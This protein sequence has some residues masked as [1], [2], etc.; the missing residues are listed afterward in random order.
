MESLHASCFMRTALALLRFLTSLERAK[1]ALGGNFVYCLAIH[2]LLVQLDKEFGGKVKVLAFGDDVHFLG[3]P[4]FAVS[5][6]SRWGFL[7][8]SAGADQSKEVPVL[9]ATGG[10]DHSSRGGASSQGAFYLTRHPGPWGPG[11]FR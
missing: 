1:G 5:E 7:E 2:P 10:R 11:R 4:K 8:T 9:L 6:M 3:P